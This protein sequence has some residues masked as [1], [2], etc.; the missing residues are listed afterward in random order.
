[1]ANRKIMSFSETP[2]GRV[3]LESLRWAVL[4]FISVL[5][6]QLLV[7]LPGIEQTPSIVALTL[8]LRYVDSMLH[9]STVAEKGIVRF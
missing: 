3:V 4:A 2:L 6:S 8:V 1:M 7:L 9:K 5:V